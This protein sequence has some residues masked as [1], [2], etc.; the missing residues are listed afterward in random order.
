MKRISFG[1]RLV[2]AKLEKHL[3][4][5][6]QAQIYETRVP[7]AACCRTI[8]LPDLHAGLVHRGERTPQTITP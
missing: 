3:T 8:C 7:A 5:R 4:P 6:G 1:L 2:Q